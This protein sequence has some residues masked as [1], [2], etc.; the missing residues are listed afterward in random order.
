MTII[1]DILK[2]S[3]TSKKIDTELEMVCL[4]VDDVKLLGS[5][6]LDT[7]LS[8]GSQIM[9]MILHGIINGPLKIFGMKVTSKA[10]G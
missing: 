3:H 9:G 5:E 1:N 2:V 4:G 10:K 7:P 6:L 8:G